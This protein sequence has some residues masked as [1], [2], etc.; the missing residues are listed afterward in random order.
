MLRSPQK[1]CLLAARG[2]LSCKPKL[3]S[4]STGVGR[5]Y[6][7]SKL[8]DVRVFHTNRVNYGDDPGPSSSSGGSR[9][10]GSRRGGSDSGQ[11]FH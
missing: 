2:A 11:W 1:V 6:L 7:A 9:R 3:L 8:V 4:Q 5:N 10:R